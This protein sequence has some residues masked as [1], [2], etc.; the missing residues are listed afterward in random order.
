MNGFYDV[1]LILVILG[2]GVSVMNDLAA[3]VFG[4]N[5]PESGFHITEGTV[6]E[7]QSS[8]NP[9]TVDDFTWTNI[10]LI[11]LKAIGS[12]VLAVITIIPA[13]VGLLTMCGCDPI[14][15]AALA[16]VLQ[17]PVWWITITGWFEWSTGRSLT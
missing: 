7:Y 11:G 13:V 4:I 2:G 12:A 8:T 6:T 17:G 9:T 5:L 16:V 3:P 1:V 14:I 10:I 15:A